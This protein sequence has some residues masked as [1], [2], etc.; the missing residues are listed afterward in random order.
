MSSRPFSSRAPARPAACLLFLLLFGAAL[1]GAHAPFLNLPYYWDEA[2]QFIPHALDIFQDGSLVPH[3]TLPN[4]HPPSVPAYVALIWKIAGFSPTATRAGMLALSA[5]S[6]LAAFLLAKALAKDA[7]AKTALLATALL[8][9]SPVFFA[10]SMLAQ[11]DAPAMLFTTLALLWFLEDR[12]PLAAAACLALVLVKETGVAVPL[13]LG[14]WLLYERRRR[15]AAWFVAPVAALLCWVGLLAAATGHWSG[16]RQFLEY[17]VYYP[18][19]PLRLAAAILRRLYY[20]FIGDSHW[21]GA[22]ALTLA[23]RRGMFRTRAWRVAVLLAVANVATVT[24]LGGAVLNRYLLP[25]MPVLY[26]GI[27]AGL[28]VF[29]RVP[30]VALSGALLTGLVAGNFVN[31]P[32]PFALEDNLSFV[33]FVRLHQE[34]S[35]YLE[36]AYPEARAAALWPISLELS[37]PALGFLRK[38]LK[39]REIADL[40]PESLEKIDWTGREVFVASSRQCTPAWSVL[41]YEP[42]LRLTRAIY[43]PVRD[44]QRS[45]IGNYARFPLQARFERGGQWVDI[46]ANPRRS[47]DAQP[48]KSRLER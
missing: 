41:R 29:R 6:L 37:R 32:Y 7:P 38:P 44:V 8:F 39:V 43:G 12:I 4:I 23:W 3:S 47:S 40:S 34:S 10:Q 45:E 16:N 24:V 15:D 2:G 27:A 30:R 33:D 9:V 5:L 11:L 14:G 19:D 22:I 20:L 35:A 46:Y 28:S 17:N 13:T 26:A 31:P 21:V 48:R 18:L 36:H 42:V 1:F 25:A